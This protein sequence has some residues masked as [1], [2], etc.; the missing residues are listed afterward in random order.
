MQRQL[1]I[2]E[3]WKLVFNIDS[4]MMYNE[5]FFLENAFQ[6]QNIISVLTIF[7][8]AVL[9]SMDQVNSDDVRSTDTFF[10]VVL[11]FIHSSSI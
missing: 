6:Y 3:K 8:D 2:S 10:T 7:A 9:Y 4:I 5:L 1:G 11:I